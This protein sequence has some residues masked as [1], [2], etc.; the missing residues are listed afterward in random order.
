MVGQMDYDHEKVDEMV[1]ALLSLGVWEED[2][3]GARAWKSLDWDA[4]DRL[5]AKGYITNPRGKAKSV[6]LSPESLKKARELFKRH[7]G[8]QGEDG[9]GLHGSAPRRTVTD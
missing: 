2:E 6:G 8:R 5:H 1:L 9:K 3:W 4:M 7:F